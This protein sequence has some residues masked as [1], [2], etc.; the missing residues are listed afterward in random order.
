MN[1]E[2]VLYRDVM[3]KDQLLQLYSRIADCHICPNMDPEKA[4]RR[5][6]GVYPGMDIFIISQSLAETQ[7]RMSGVNFFN[8]KGDLGSTGKNLER[9]LNLFG[10]T[11]YPPTEIRLSS[12][13]L[14]PQCKKGYYSVYN[15]ELTQCF[16]GKEANGR[17]RE[18]DKEAIKKCSGQGFVEEEIRLIKPKLILLMGEKSRKAFYQFSLGENR[19]DNLSTHLESIISKRSIPKIKVLGQEVYVLPIQHASGANRLFF[20]MVQDKKLVELI[21]GVLK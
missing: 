19:N 12:G 11:V 13:S 17:D 14:I 16:P 3:F 6:E 15:T 1:W 10:R 8:L 5:P 2:V 21:K 18:P 7:L 4:F 9:F 20:S